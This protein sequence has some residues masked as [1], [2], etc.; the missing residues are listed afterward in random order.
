MVVSFDR[1]YA[2]FALPSKRF[3]VSSISGIGIQF[4]VPI[5]DKAIE[6]DWSRVIVHAIWCHDFEDEAYNETYSNS[7]FD[8]KLWHNNSAYRIRS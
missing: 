1:W 6:K 5:S 3:M 8:E 7:W 4:W 2:M